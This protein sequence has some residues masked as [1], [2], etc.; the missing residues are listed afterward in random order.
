MNHINPDTVNID[1]LSI[2][3]L[4]ID[5]PSIDTPSIDTPSIDTPSIDTN[6]IIQET[7]DVFDINS[8]FIEDIERLKK[9]KRLRNNS[10]D[11]TNHVEFKIPDIYSYSLLNTQKFN[12]K[13]LKIILKK[14]KLKISGNKNELIKRAYNFLHQSYYAIK[15]QKN[16]RKK[17]VY[18]FFKY[19]GPNSRNIES[20][21]NETDFATLEK[22][23]TY[24]FYEIITIK[25]NDKNIYGFHIE[26]LFK[27][28]N[29]VDNNQVVQN[30][31][32]RN[33]MKYSKDEL[34]CFISKIY[35]IGKILNY[36]IIYNKK[37]VEINKTVDQKIKELFIN[38]DQLGNYTDS[39]W[40]LNLSTGRMIRFLFE[41]KDIWS[42]RSNIPEEVK[43]N[44]CHPHGNPFV[45]IPLNHVRTINNI[46]H[47]K[48]ICFK[49]IDSMI[50]MGINDEN[51]SLGALYVLTALTIVSQPAANTLPWLY[52]S[53]I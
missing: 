45:N 11:K 28:I 42:Y 20:C 17:N 38:M 46:N 8:N 43:R 25:D 21:I 37:P 12:V 7:N 2:D 1:T 5:T 3:T 6:N 50:N 13:E 29:S 30:P 48:T 19:L 41:L 14:Y 40:L 51:K 4:S 15:I 35:K 24:P 34:R 32:N 9:F 52:E 18:N 47:I 26:S 10:I 33:N 23:N 22:L 44:I 49:V 39:S 27:L 53:V 16:I 36:N 31:F